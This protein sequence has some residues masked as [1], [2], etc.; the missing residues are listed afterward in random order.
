[1]DGAPGIVYRA[2]GETAPVLPASLQLTPGDVALVDAGGVAKRFDTLHPG[3]VLQPDNGVSWF[4]QNWWRWGIPAAL[5][6]LFLV[7]LLVASI[8]R[9]RHRDKT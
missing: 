1:V 6:A 4:V 9:R 2:T 3:E 5:V 7:L 8:A